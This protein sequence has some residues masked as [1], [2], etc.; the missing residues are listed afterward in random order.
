VIPAASEQQIQ[1]T[2]AVGTSFNVYASYD[3]KLTWN[4]L[5]KAGKLTANSFDWTVPALIKSAPQC[6]I[7]VVGYN[8]AETKVEAAKSNVFAI[9]VLNM[10]H[11]AGAAD[12]LLAG[13]IGTLTWNVGTGAPYDTTTLSYSVD[14]G[15]TWLPIATLTGT[16]GPGS[17]SYAWTVPQRPAETNCVIKLTLT[18]AGTVVAK[19]KSAVF[20]IEVT[21]KTASDASGRYIMG[22]ISV[23]NMNTSPVPVTALDDVQMNGAGLLNYTTIASSDG[24]NDAETNIPYTVSGSGLLSV[25]GEGGPHGILSTDNR[26]ALLADTKL[27]GDLGMAM[28]VKAPASPGLSLFS[29]AY[30]GGSI[31]VNGIILF[32]ITSDGAGN[33]TTHC[34]APPGACF[35]DSSGTYSLNPDGTFTLLGSMRGVINEDGTVFTGADTSVNSFSFV[36]GMKKPLGPVSNGVLAGKFVGV[37]IGVDT[38]PYTSVMKLNFDGL[39]DGGGK[40]SLSFAELYSNSS[41]LD[42]GTGKYIVLPDGTLSA[43]PTGTKLK[44]VVLENGQGFFLMDTDPSDNDI[45][46]I[47]GL[48]TAK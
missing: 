28:L 31:G 8:D 42:S 5:N 29:G 27:D 40:G 24:S 26:V 41:T 1:W 35:P 9:D 47:I 34:I 38:S 11:P 15:L 36:V 43:G 18:H 32:E 23:D 46:M 21:P 4:L 2:G 37:Q 25:G 20:P 44:G 3:N 33:F 7:K 12:G 6:F 30:M 14:G 39:T 45:S 17:H 22:S 16:N 13:Q 19:G 10:T 48:K